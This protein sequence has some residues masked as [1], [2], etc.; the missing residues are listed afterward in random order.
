MSNYLSAL[1]P[2]LKGDKEGDYSAFPPVLKELPADCADVAKWLQAIIDEKSGD[3]IA[4]MYN[5]LF[6][7]PRDQVNVKGEIKLLGHLFREAERYRLYKFEETVPNAN[8]KTSS[9]LESAAVH[10]TNR[11]V[12]SP[13]ALMTKKLKAQL[14]SRARR[15]RQ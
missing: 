10:V 8:L 13:S 14:N 2:Y 12:K 15:Q 6:A 1:L 5:H 9:F 4:R 11:L 7:P 3:A